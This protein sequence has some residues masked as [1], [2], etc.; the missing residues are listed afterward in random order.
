MFT[1]RPIDAADDAE[2]R[3]VVAFSVMSVWET[4]PELR[5][6]LHEEHGFSFDEMERTY[7]RDA[8][9]RDHRI[10]VALD[11]EGRLAG[12]TAFALKKDHEDVVYGNCYAR[13]VLPIHRRKGLASQFLEHALGW[14]RDHGARYAVA[15]PH[16][17]NEPLV[18]LFERAGFR[19]VD[20]LDGRWPTWVLRRDLTP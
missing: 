7:R 5:V 8:A 14:F 17:D 4:I 15:H 20:R 10:L 3:G 13:Y 18:A 2:L 16:A 9:N 12:H 6:D 11:A 19:K 1:I